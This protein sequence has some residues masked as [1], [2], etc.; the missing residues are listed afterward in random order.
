[1]STLR[2]FL[3]SCARARAQPLACLIAADWVR[4][5]TGVDPVSWYRHMCTTRESVEGLL[6]RHPLLWYMAQGAEQAGLEPISSPQPG[7]IGV[8]IGGGHALAGVCLGDRWAVA[9]ADRP[10]IVTRGSCIAAWRVP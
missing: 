7:D 1:M 2:Q 8:V 6:S 10:L 4:A 3:D 5:R 9:T